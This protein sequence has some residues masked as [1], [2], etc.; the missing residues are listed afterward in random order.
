MIGLIVVVV[1]LVLSIVLSIFASR[2]WH[3]AHVMVVFLLAFSMI[4]YS[5]LAFRVLQIRAEHQKAE[6]DALERLEDQQQIINA[7]DRGTTNPQ[8]VN[9]LAE[10]LGLDEDAEQ[11]TSIGDLEHQLRMVNRERGRLWD[12]VQPLGMPDQQTR[13]VRVG[14]A[15]DAPALNVS[16]GA[17]LYAFEQGSPDDGAD[18]IGEFRVV[19][20]APR[21]LTLEP[22]LTLDERTGNR[23]FDSAQQ[24]SVW[25]L[26][27]SMPVDTHEMFAGMTEEQLRAILPEG[28]VQEYVRHGT[29]LEPDDDPYR[30]MGVDEDGT[31]L[32]PEAV[33]T[34]EQNDQPVRKIYV[35]K[36]RDYAFLFQEYAQRQQEL[37]NQRRAIESNLQRVQSALAGAKQQLAMRKETLQK[38]QHDMAGV[39]RDKQA[40]DAYLAEA[41]QRLRTAEELLQQ[42]LAAN[43][44]SASRLG[45]LQQGV[46]GGA[47]LNSTPVPARGAVDPHAL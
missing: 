18:Y 36:L 6:H 7:I 44:R 32:G 43:V 8:M 29:P 15:E 35:R 2:Y 10:P 47:D 42:T 34:L 12:N 39:L 33:R 41:Q 5:N 24:Q 4:G 45:E 9:R 22:V 1:V 14:V 21:E 31:L 40:I 25:T 23:Y 17:I 46:L 30:M 26:H 38:L 16:Q 13:R 27:E 19:E 28:A 11:I 20:A 37:R 3:W